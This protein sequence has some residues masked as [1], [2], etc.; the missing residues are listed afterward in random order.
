MSIIEFKGAPFPAG[1]PHFTLADMKAGNVTF[2]PAPNANGEDRFEFSFTDDVNTVTGQMFTLDITPV[3]DAAEVDL[4]SLRLT[5]AEDAQATPI[6]ID[7]TDIDTA[8]DDLSIDITVTTVPEQGTLLFKGAPFPAGDPHFTLADMKAGNVTFQPAPNANGEDH[9]EFSFTDD[10]NT[11]TGQMF[12]LNITAIDDP[13][14][15]ASDNLSLSL[16][17]NSAA[18]PIKIELTP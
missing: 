6:T 14:K 11:V 2:Q 12:N 8:A 18:I 9:F 10:V 16:V 15:L 5:L 3:D 4:A 1:D 7:F 17:E 13:T